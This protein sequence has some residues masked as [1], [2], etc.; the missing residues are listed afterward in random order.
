[1]GKR[2]TDGTWEDSCLAKVKPEEPI[3]VLRA[4]DF[5]APKLVRAWAIQAKAVG[6]PL[7]KVQEALDCAD[8][9]DKWPTRKWPD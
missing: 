5:I 6:C 8:S 9:M 7:E 3:F 1:M 4:Q 2:N